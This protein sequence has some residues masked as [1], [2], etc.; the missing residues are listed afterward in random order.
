M[1]PDTFVLVSSLPLNPN[2]KVDRMALPLPDALN[3][4][5][6]A[7]TAE[8]RTPIGKRLAEILEGL[9]EVKEIGADD[10]FF[11]LGGHSLLGTQLIARVQDIFGVP[12][13]LRVLFDSPTIAELSSHIERL[14]VAQSEAVSEDEAQRLRASQTRPAQEAI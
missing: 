9:L 5:R 2:G 13:S 10:N 8:L 4:L 11:L 7:S 12:V 6:D 1:V 14:I 3:T